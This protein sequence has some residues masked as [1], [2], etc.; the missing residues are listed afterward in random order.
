MSDET[1]R[2]LRKLRIRQKDVSA[3]VCDFNDFRESRGGRREGGNSGGFRGNGNRDNNRRSGN[4]N[5]GERSERRFDR[6]RGG[7]SRGSYRGERG[8]STSRRRSE[9]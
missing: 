1:T 6:N 5:G 8:H 2:K 7:D 3:V 9:G 4:G